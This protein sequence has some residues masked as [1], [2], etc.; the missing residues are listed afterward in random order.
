MSKKQLAVEPLPGYP[1]EIGAWLWALEDSRRRTLRAIKDLPAEAVDWTPSEGGDS[2]G[3][4]LY[5]LAAIEADWLYSDVLGKGFSPEV[6]DLLPMNVRDEAGILSPVKGESLETHLKRLEIIRDKLLGAFKD[7]TI[8]DFH[9]LRA[10]EDYE[11]TPQWVI[12]HLMQHEAVHR[13][14]IEGLR[15]SYQNQ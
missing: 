2:I 15:F 14:Q 5:H 3:T 12:H 4:L 10:V 8:A 11:V 1:P 13:S 6:M 7:I 9:K